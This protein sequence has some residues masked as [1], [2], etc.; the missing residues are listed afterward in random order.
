LSGFAD[1]GPCGVRAGVGSG[2]VTAGVGAAVVAGFAVFVG[3]G[4]FSAGFGSVVTVGPPPFPPRCA[5]STRSMTS[6]L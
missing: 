3:F 6:L 5:F 2:V 4:V 1:G